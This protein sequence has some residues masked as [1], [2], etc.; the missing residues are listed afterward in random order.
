M[1]ARKWISEA[2]MWMS[3]SEAQKTWIHN[4]PDYPDWTLPP[5]HG[6]PAP[7]FIR[8]WQGASSLNEVKKVLFWCSLDDLEAQRNRINE[9]LVRHHYEP[10]QP[11]SI[12]ST[13][14]LSETQ[15]ANRE[16]SY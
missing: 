1:E 4:P 10:L 12:V 2:L 11:L 13:A 6:V 14:M 16:K 8:T 5:N 15:H 3:F 9:F 7:H